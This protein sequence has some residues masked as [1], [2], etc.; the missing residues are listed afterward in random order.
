MTGGPGPLG[1]VWNLVGPVGLAAL[2]AVLVVV[3]ALGFWLGRRWGTAP[4][5]G[6]STASEER[7]VG[8]IPQGDAAEALYFR[9][10]LQ[11][12]TGPIAI[13]SLDGRLLLV[14]EKF[15]AIH[16]TS[17]GEIAGKPIS[18][19]YP[20]DRVAF[21]LE[22]D[23]QMLMQGETT[24]NEV[25]AAAVDGRRIDLLTTRFPI[26]DD[27]GQIV[28]IGTF[29]TDITELKRTEAELTRYR[30]YLEQLV[31]ERTE[32]LRLLNEHKDRFF[33]IIAHDL[34]GPFNALLGYSEMIYRKADEMD[35]QTVTAFAKQMYDSATMAYELL[36]NL[37]QWSRLQ[38][39][40]VDFNPTAVP[41]SD[42]IARTVRLMAQ[43]AGEKEITL[44]SDVDHQAIV[45]IDPATLETV[46]RNVVTN[47]IKFTERGGRIDIRAIPNG[48]HMHLTVTD[49]GVGIDPDRIDGVMSLDQQHST[50]GTEGEIGTGLGLRLCQE[51]LVR[52]GGSI[53]LD[54]TP[55]AG[56]TVTI[57][58]PVPAYGAGRV[59]S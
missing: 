17:P 48:D 45:H 56:T 36:E 20:P 57:E 10:L 40:R 38:M 34:R 18:A 37:L 28:G 12:A 41:L 21:F 24:H 25:Q 35:R 44:E 58:L 32:E 13:K 54:S 4:G 5:Q 42:T 46:L 2:F 7:K 49:T 55:G 33:S 22:K 52:Q 6:V 30:D 9:E 16:G 27:T 26:R 23:R 11:N 53:S 14:N 15:A 47:A 3:G 8:G 50:R 39:D 43:A 59:A 1:E 51:M 29:N 19:L 31:E